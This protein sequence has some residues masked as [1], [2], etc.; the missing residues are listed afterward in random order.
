MINKQ[1]TECNERVAAIVEGGQ[2]LEEYVKTPGGQAD[3]NYLIEGVNVGVD[4]TLEVI[5]EN[6]KRY[7]KLFPTGF[8]LLD[9]I[10]GG[11]LP[12]GITVIAAPPGQGKS[13][14]A[15]QMSEYLSSNGTQV[16]YLTNDMKEEELVLKMLS[17]NTYNLEPNGALDVSEIRNINDYENNSLMQAAIKL[18]K[19]HTRLFA[20]QE[21]EEIRTLKQILK[22]IDFFAL[23]QP[24]RQFVVVLDY[25]QKVEIKGVS[26]DKER[27]D[28]LIKGLKDKAMEHGIPIVVISSVN[29][30]SY[31]VPLT[32][33]SLKE[34]G[35]LEYGADVII[36]I[37]HK[38][39][40]KE[41][42]DLSA[43]KSEREACMELVLLKN[44]H[45]R[46]DVIIP[47]QFDA[48]YN[49]FFE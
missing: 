11:G 41:G 44:R 43:A 15:L 40:G 5:L 32:M 9:K 24:E 27:A 46:S 1:W 12:A 31:R 23:Y 45:G 26:N 42:F 10:L 2:S 38:N 48:Q 49:R 3:I 22:V 37:Q 17:R 6:A 34:S 4:S 33:D 47:I 35:G 19:E 30:I 7:G 21:A 16:L 13:T 14:F 28:Q 29:R 25:L 39:V 18:V 36:G 8:N 20:I